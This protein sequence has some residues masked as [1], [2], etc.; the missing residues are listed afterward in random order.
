MT[1][2]KYY[3]EKPVTEAKFKTRE[4]DVFDSPLDAIKYT[5]GIKS[6]VREDVSSDYVLAKCEPITQ[7]YVIEQATIAYI[8]KLFLQ[9][10]NP[11]A[12]ERIFK[13]IMSH[14]EMVVIMHRNVPQNYIV[15]MYAPQL[16]RTLDEQTDDTTKKAI[17]GIA[18]KAK[19]LERRGNPA[20]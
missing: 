2:K 1:K 19:K 5:S 7:N 10:A 18:E 9:K 14:V 4:D 15:S 12:A 20:S 6:R 17:N 16:E 8:F 11:H 3:I 13:K